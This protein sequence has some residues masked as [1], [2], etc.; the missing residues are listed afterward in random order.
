MR[1]LAVR[2]VAVLATIALI[3]AQLTGAAHDARARHVVCAHGELVDAPALAIHARDVSQLLAVDRPDGDDAHCAIAG[4]M[5][6]AGS[7]DTAAPAVAAARSGSTPAP[8]ELVNRSAI[9]TLYR[10]APKTSPPRASLR[11][12]EH[13]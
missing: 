10:I 6:Q 7:S 3:A 1:G 4:A 13:S 5:H 8:V 12:L 11:Q 2:R 9:A